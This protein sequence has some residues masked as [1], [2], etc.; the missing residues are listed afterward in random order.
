MRI[1]DAAGNLREER[2]IAREGEAHRFGESAGDATPPQLGDS[3]RGAFGR[4]NLGNQVTH[5]QTATFVLNSGQT[6]QN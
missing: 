2:R 5:S 6:S 1:Q 3:R 4:E